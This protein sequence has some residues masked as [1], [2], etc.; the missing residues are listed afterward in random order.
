MWDPTW[1]SSWPYFKLHLLFLGHVNRHCTP[2]LTL[3][4]IFHLAIRIVITW[5]ICS[6]ALDHKQHK[7]LGVVFHQYHNF[8][9]HINSIVQTCHLKRKAHPFS[10]LYH[11]NSLLTSL[12]NRAVTHQHLVENRSWNTQGWGYITVI[13][14]K[15]QPVETAQLSHGLRSLR[16]L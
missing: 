11:C 5:I 3:N 10:I 9:E 4:Y 8:N 7:N 15:L 13:L 12:N 1:L 14:E 16:R 6:P 2:V